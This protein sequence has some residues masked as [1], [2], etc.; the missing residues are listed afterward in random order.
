MKAGTVASALPDAAY[1]RTAS[2]TAANAGTKGKQRLE[3]VLGCSAVAC[4]TAKLLSAEGG[5]TRRAKEET[6]Y[7]TCVLGAVFSVVAVVR[8]TAEP[9]EPV[10]VIVTLMAIPLGGGLERRY[11]H[12]LLHPNEILVSGRLSVKV[13]RKPK[14]RKTK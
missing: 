5:Q 11:K 6:F 13:C 9:Y 8:K 12:S 4:V 3:P 10:S 7:L 2:A 14:F 1:R